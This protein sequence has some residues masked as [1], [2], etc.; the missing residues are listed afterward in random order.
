MMRTIRR[1]IPL[2]AIAVILAAQTEDFTFYPEFR[3]WW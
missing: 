2:A 1:L 3:T